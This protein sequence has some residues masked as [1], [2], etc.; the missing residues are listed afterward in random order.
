MG[1]FIGLCLALAAGLVILF[2]KGF[3]PLRQCYGLKLRTPNAGFIIPGAAVRVA[4]VPVGNVDRVGLEPEGKSVIIHLRILRQHP[5][6]RD[7]KFIIEQIGFL[8]D[9]FISIVPQQNV[10][11]PLQD[12]D[13]VTCDEP[14]N[15][16][17][18]ARSSVGLIRRVDQSVQRLDR[19]V[20][21]VDQ[22][23][24][25]EPNLVNTTNAIA[26]LR[27]LSE[28]AFTT[29]DNF[30][31]L[32][33]TN[34]APVSAVMSNLT[35][36]SVELSLLSDD[37]RTLVTT[38]QPG[39]TTVVKNLEQASAT[40]DTLL[41]DLRAGKG[42]A[43]FLLSDEQTKGQMAALLNNLVTLSS[44][45]NQHGLLYKPKPPRPRD[46]ES[47]PRIGGRKP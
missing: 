19:A 47:Y 34:A 20:A 11:P 10:G 30:E 7:A 13:E 36:F 16:Q 33:V 26:N 15:L 23:L 8:G 6:R 45:L 18:V 17:E 39:V 14:F 40:V 5:I 44:N 42:L 9:Q 24:L 21:R 37:L 25:A 4:G 28:R 29:L 41:S 12:G 43:G 1:L 38:N 22:I 32:M 27:L 46:R 31:R 3:S 35:H 2:S